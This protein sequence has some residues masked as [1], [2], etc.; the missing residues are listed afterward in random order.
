[1]E[2]H[3]SQEHLALLLRELPPAPAGWVAAAKALPDARRALDEVDE[4]VLRD[5]PARAAVTAELEAALRRARIDPSPERVAA[6]RRL[7]GERR[8]DR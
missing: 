1:M 4:R 7:V 5:A 2:D 8:G 6:L 3:A